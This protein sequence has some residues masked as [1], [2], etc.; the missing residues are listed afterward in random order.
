MK[1]KLYAKYNIRSRLIEF[2][3]IEV[4]DDEA[5]YKYASANMQAAETNPFY[6][7]E[8]YRLICLGVINMEGSPKE[9][10]II[11]EYKNDYPFVFGEL[12]DFQKPKHN[13]K[14]F[15]NMN[16]KNEAEKQKIINASK[17][18]EQEEGE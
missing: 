12:T 5:A 8:D 13:Q 16:A 10:G 18:I 11:Y 15:N 7:E 2:I 1:R 14:Y 9:V 6:N 3:F 4:N 17:K